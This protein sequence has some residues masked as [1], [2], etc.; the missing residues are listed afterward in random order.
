VGKMRLKG[1]FKKP[2]EESDKENILQRGCMY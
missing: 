2:W 1:S